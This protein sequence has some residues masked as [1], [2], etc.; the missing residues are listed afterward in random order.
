M[1]IE[2][3]DRYPERRTYIDVGWGIRG[4]DR[5]LSYPNISGKNTPT[6]INV[7]CELCKNTPTYIDVGGRLV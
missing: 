5:P 1:A 2:R 6:Y 3:R 7:G 4:G